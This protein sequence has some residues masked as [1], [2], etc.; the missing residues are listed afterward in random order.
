[1][2][3]FIQFSLLTP[4]NR[5]APSSPKQ[6][7]LLTKLVGTLNK[8][9]SLPRSSAD[10]RCLR[11]KLSPAFTSASHTDHPQTTD[12]WNHSSG[13]TTQISKAAALRRLGVPHLLEAELASL[14]YNF[15]IFSIIPPPPPSGR[16]VKP[17]N[18]KKSA[19]M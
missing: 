16:S 11:A 15:H 12:G 3:E 5:E 13:K 8:A 19:G 17:R 2:L 9:A 18:K 14:L 1:M 6:T 4:L 10:A 7:E